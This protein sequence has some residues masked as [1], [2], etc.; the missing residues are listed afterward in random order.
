VDVIADQLGEDILLLDIQEVSIITDYFVIASAASQRQAKAIV[1][2]VQEDVK[3]EFDLKPM[4]VDGEA[5]S[6]WVLLDYNHIIVHIFTPEVRAY[7]DLEG[8]WKDARI[9]VRML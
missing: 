1:E 8:L 5:D 2:K 6:G 3:G 9:V 7:Y 4:G